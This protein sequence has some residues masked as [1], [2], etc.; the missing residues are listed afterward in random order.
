MK[1]LIIGVFTLVMV[2]NSYGQKMDAT[3]SV[4]N[5]K[6]PNKSEK[7]KLYK[8][9]GFVS[10]AYTEDNSNNTRNYKRQ[11]NNSSTPS[12]ASFKSDP[13]RKEKNPL[14]SRNHYKSQFGKN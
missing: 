11:N 2:S 8:K 12:G 10:E 1:A 9:E 3:Y 13:I 4:H 14:T 5:Y 7:A 6:H